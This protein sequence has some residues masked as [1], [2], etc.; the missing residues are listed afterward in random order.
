MLEQKTSGYVQG[1]AIEHRKMLTGPGS[2]MLVDAIFSARTADAYGK[3]R[4]DPI[5]LF[6]SHTDSV[7]CRSFARSVYAQD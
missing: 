2:D 7:A 1:S 6:R 3:N 4:T 5:F